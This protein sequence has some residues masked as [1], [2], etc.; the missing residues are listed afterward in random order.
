MKASKIQHLLKFFKKFG[1]LVS[2]IVNT[3]LEILPFLIIF[4]LWDLVFALIYMDLGAYKD[5]IEA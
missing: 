1:L 4:I 5:E 3:S 2:L